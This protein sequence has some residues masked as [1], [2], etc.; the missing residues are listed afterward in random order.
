MARVYRV[1]ESRTI[2]WLTRFNPRQ[3]SL[4]SSN[5][6]VDF[7]VDLNDRLVDQ[8]EPLTDVRTRKLIQT[9]SAMDNSA[10]ARHAPIKAVV[11]VIGMHVTDEMIEAAKPILSASQLFA[12][13]ALQIAQQNPDRSTV[14]SPNT[15]S[16][17]FH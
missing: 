5:L 11:Q 2:L 16:T 7:R 1:G 3:I 14:G 12:L 10:N 15:T 8:G 9:F 13:R 17:P 6:D 4:F